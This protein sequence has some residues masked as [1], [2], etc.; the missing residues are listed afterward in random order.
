MITVGV[1]T[2]NSLDAVDAVLTRFDGGRM[3]DL[4]ACSLPYPAEL[5][6]GFLTLRERIARHGYDVSFL[7]NDNP[8]TVVLKSCTDLVAETVNTLCRGFDKSEIAAIGLHGQTCG[9]FPPSVAGDAAPYTLQVFDPARLAALTDLPV[10]YDFRSD[11]MANGG[12]GAPLAPIHNAHIAADLKEK[13][14]FPVAFC[15]AGNTGN[16]A[17][18]SETADGKSVTVGWDAGPFNHFADTLSRFGANEPCDLNGRFGARGRIVPELLADL[19]DTAAVTG[20][21]ENFYLLPP[22]KSSDPSWYRI[23]AADV[24]AR[25]GFENAL[26]TVEYLGAYGFMTALSMIGENV[27]MPQSF[28]LFGGGW[29]NPLALNDF[30]D[31]LNGKG[32][33]LPRHADVFARVRA[34]FSRPPAVDFSDRYGYSGTYMEARIFADMARCRITGEPFSFPE[35]TGCKSPTVA[36]IYALPPAGAPLLDGLF[37]QYGTKDLI[38]NPPPRLFSR[39]AKES[40]T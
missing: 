28:L 29:K 1:M 19:F 30:K 9:H 13:G 24:C 4:A 21:G 10:I 34:R 40:R 31:L 25:F 11:D 20:N 17:V 32:I 2:G 8:F 33:V 5:R 23:D 14:L 39:A 35:T 12:E 27:K 36:G 16:I 22:P 37:E 18:V 26:R 15:N 7:K 6:N 3:A 38:P